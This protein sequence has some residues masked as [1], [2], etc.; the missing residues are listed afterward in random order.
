MFRKDVE[1]K[2][3]PQELQEFLEAY[4]TITK[5]RLDNLQSI[6]NFVGLEE[7]KDSDDDMY[8]SGISIEKNEKYDLLV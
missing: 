6:K 8:T 1:Y 4:K 2:V 5:E 3:A 7:E